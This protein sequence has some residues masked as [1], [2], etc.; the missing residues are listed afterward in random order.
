MTPLSPFIS[1]MYIIIYYYGT[2]QVLILQLTTSS[3]CR[4][5][6]LQWRIKAINLKSWG[7]KKTNKEFHLYNINSKLANSILYRTV[8]WKMRL[9]MIVFLEAYWLCQGF[10]TAL[11][12]LPTTHS[13][14]SL[15][16]SAT[17]LSAITVATSQVSAPSYATGL[18]KPFWRPDY[19]GAGRKLRAMTAA[20]GQ[21]SEMCV[22]GD[23]TL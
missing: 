14:E 12:L 5:L 19:K 23:K 21:G 20:K 15:A 1:F 18:P 7:T 6:N 13:S 16:F 2:R 22:T 10:L 8:I 11:S 3:H 17:G 9:L 4:Y